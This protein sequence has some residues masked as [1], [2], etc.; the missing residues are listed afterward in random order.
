MLLGYSSCGELLSTLGRFRDASVPPKFTRMK[1]RAAYAATVLH[2][3]VHIYIC[4][5]IC[6]YFHINRYMYVYIYIC[7]CVCIYT[8][9]HVLIYLYTHTST[10]IYIY[11]HICT[12]VRV[13][14]YIYS[15]HICIC[16]DTCIHMKLQGLCQLPY[17]FRKSDSQYTHQR[18]FR[19]PLLSRGDSSLELIKACTES[20]ILHYIILY[21]SALYDILSLDPQ[22]S[23]II[24]IRHT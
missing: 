10:C 7:V 23:R 24:L 5:C 15:M 3:H 16:T 8:Y 18:L 19:R 17:G 21:S 6:I 13:G 14:I 20:H 11:I 2:I 12:Q 4:I 22:N 1:T 9:I